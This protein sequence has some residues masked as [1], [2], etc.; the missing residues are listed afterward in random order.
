MPASRAR[1][2]PRW[3]LIGR[4]TRLP[5]AEALTLRRLTDAR[6]GVGRRAVMAGLVACLCERAGPS[7]PALDHPGRDAWRNCS[8]RSKP[9]GGNDR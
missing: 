9:S 8:D 2:R 1:P 3:R 5:A 4:R 6:P 7:S